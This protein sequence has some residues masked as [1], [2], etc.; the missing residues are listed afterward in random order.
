MFKV[1]NNMKNLVS[2]NRFFFSKD[3]FFS[4]SNPIKERVVSTPS[5]PVPYY[6]RIAK[7]Y[8]IRCT[9]DSK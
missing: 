1:A 8:P 7:A 2:C 4:N 9:L 5:W 6:Q 3:L